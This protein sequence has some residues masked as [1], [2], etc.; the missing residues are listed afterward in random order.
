[1]TKRKVAADPAPVDLRCPE[2][3]AAARDVW[4]AAIR[5]MAAAHTLSPENLPLVERYASA[6]LRWREAE[7]MIL[8]GGAV[9]AAPRSKVPMANPWLSISRSAA[10]AATRLE[11][12]LGLSPARRGRA[13][14]PARSLR[15]DGSARPAAWSIDDEDALGCAG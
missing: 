14:R 10:A 13:S 15:A 11:A 4:D 1:M 3:L 12:E 6:H 8:D 2:W 5:A 9:I 7:R